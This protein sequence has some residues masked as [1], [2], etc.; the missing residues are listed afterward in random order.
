MRRGAV[1]SYQ[2]YTQTVNTEWHWLKLLR[3]WDHQFAV[4][5]RFLIAREQK[6]MSSLLSKFEPT[7]LGYSA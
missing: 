7:S 6:K 3:A 2:E 4:S 5:G 1:D